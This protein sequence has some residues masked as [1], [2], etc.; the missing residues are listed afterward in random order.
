MTNSARRPGIE[1][2]PPLRV[3][4]NE[5]LPC[6]AWRFVKLGAC[7]VYDAFS[8]AGFM[9]TSAERAKMAAVME[10]CMKEEEFKVF[11]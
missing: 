8:N 11:V 3:L 6:A 1:Q 2:S 10:T 7:A 9:T 4:K 5:V